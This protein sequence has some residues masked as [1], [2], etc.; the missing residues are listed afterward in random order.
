[1]WRAL[2]CSLLVVVVPTCGNGDQPATE[3]LGPPVAPPDLV[4]RTADQ[5]TTVTAYGYHSRTGVADGTTLP[6]D[7]PAIVIDAY[8]LTIEFPEPSWEFEGYLTP[9]GDPYGGGQH[10]SVERVAEGRF[11]LTPPTGDGTYDV[12]RNGSGN[13][14]AAGF[15][16]RWVGACS[17]SDS[18]IV[19]CLAAFKTFGPDT[20]R[21]QRVPSALTRSG[22]R[23]RTSPGERAFALEGSTEAAPNAR[24]WP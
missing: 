6:A 4:I 10:L 2:A 1:M 14:S 11:R 5:T 24:S 15:V 22:T 18:M 8:Q 16:F 19:I 13:G 17:R 9:P 21:R 7:R 12:W 20:K 3:R 23:D